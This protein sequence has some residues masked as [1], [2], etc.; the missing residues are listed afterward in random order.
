[1]RGRKENEG[2]M[3]RRMEM[4]CFLRRIKMDVCMILDS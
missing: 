1:M 3:G 2:E 4:F